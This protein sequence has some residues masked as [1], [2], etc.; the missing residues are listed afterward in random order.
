MKMLLGNAHVD[1]SDGKT[2]DVVN[3]ATGKAIDTVPAATVEDV[4]RAVAIAVKA[5]TAW[6][7]R[8]VRERTDIVRR[9][10]TLV[11]ER[12]Q[13]LAKSL[14]QESGKPYPGETVGEIARVAYVYEVA[15]EVAKHHYG[16][17]MPIGLEPGFE[18]DIQLT[19]H[20]ALGVI[21]CI[22]PFNFPVTLWAYK[23]APALATG[24]AVIV[25]APSQNPLTLL[26]LHDMLVEAGVPAE[27]VQILT[28]SGSLIGGALSKDPRIAQINFTGSTATGVAIATAAAPSLTP[29]M[30]EL[31]GNDPLIICADADLDLAVREAGD[32]S[33]N[34]GQACSGAKRFI[35][36]N[37]IREEFV[38]RLIEERLRPLRLGDPLDPETTMGPL[39]NEDAA[40]GV[41]RQVEL[42]VAQGAT[43]AFGGTRKGAFYDPTVL[44]DVTPSMDIA[45]DMEVFGPVWP[46]IGFD[47]VEEAIEI[48]N[49]S[50]YGLGG[51][52]ITRNMK[53]AFRIAKAL[54][55]GHVAINAS[56]GFRSAELPFGGGRKASGNSR[57]S[58]TTVISE[59]TQKKSLILRHVLGEE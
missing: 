43:C 4:D 51:G 38:S 10:A 55:T 21:A 27:V 40:K 45:R 35:V 33:R 14:S 46:V 15:C 56:G 39:I 18:Q 26:K 2:F 23:V 19:I 5:Q 41:E 17:T 29:T 12:N 31:G 42:T 8:T 20:E 6:E 3:P 36:H 7:A 54:K 1:S 44:T 50:I 49:S 52:V 53:T 59:V 25:K 9:F 34:A 16:E 32:K 30:F 48:A 11:R 22:V 24:N 58:M 47:T 13:E 37:S 28:G 57:E